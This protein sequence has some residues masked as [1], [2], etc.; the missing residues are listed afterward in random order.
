MKY[1]VDIAELRKRMIENDCDTI[2]KLS[3]AS[4]V[5]RNTVADVV[6]GRTF[7]SSIVMSKI[8]QALNI[9][10]NDMGSIFFKQ[11]LA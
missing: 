8:G 6:K 4:G 10:S 1:E 11:K 5:N 9:S 3:D 2:E 7:P